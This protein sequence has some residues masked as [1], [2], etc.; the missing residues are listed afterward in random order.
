[1]KRSRS[2][3][4][5]M[6]NECFSVKRE[7]TSQC[8]VSASNKAYIYVSSSRKNAK[9]KHNS[10]TIKAYMA[11]KNINLNTVKIMQ[12]MQ[13][14]FINLLKKWINPL[15]PSTK[16]PPFNQSKFYKVE[17][18]WFEIVRN[19]DHVMWK[20]TL[21]L[22]HQRICGHTLTTSFKKHR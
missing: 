7:N 11:Y 14:R 8:N 19:K 10:Y 12:E 13:A 18:A 9:P 20:K 21:N 3:R 5:T 15:K 17:S 1:M 22:W 6:N 2:N 4:Q 16:P